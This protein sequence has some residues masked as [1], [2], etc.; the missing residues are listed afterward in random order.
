MFGWKKSL[1][2][3]HFL[4]DAH[5]VSTPQSESDSLFVQYYHVNF[6]SVVMS[7]GDL[8]RSFSLWPICL[9]SKKK[10]IRYFRTRK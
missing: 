3:V 1:K 2:L 8:S 9:T 7:D 10:P 4:G 6:Q 5:H